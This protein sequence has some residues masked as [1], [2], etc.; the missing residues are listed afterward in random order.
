VAGR[1][2]ATTQIDWV[3]LDRSG[4]PTRIPS[5]FDAVFSAPAVAF[6]LARVS[7]VAA[8]GDARQVSLKVRP[9]EV[10]P[11]EHVNNAVY[12]DW[13]DEAV[14]GS[15]GGRATRAIPRQMRLE[16]AA[17]AGADATVSAHV[18]PVADGWSFLVQDA[19]G[20]D[21]LRS[22]LQPGMSAFGGGAT[23]G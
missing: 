16:Y 22:R 8:P 21:L 18:W 3:L 20:R 10:D 7:L 5:E 13:L 23:T 14:I 11:M 1:L 4:A 2:V 17:P 12:V 6:G 15:G 9:Q 19:T